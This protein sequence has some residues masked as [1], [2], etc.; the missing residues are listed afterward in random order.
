ML[1]AASAV[2]IDETTGPVTRTIAPVDYHHYF[3]VVNANDVNPR[4]S[5]NNLVIN[6]EFIYGD[7][8]LYGALFSRCSLKTATKRSRATARAP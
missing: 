5:C 1:T 7:S 4:V 8:D 3:M 2:C 6:L